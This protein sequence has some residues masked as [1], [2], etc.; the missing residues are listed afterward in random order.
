MKEEYRGW[1]RFLLYAASVHF[2][3]VYTLNTRPFLDIA[4]FESGRER[5]P[6]QYRA[7]TAW[8]LAAADRSIHIPAA[9]QTRLPPRMS[10]P[11]TFALFALVVLS[12]L[13][14]V[15]AT[16]HALNYLTGR[17]A[18]SRWGALLVIAMSYFHYILDFGHPCCTP[19]QLPYD[20]PSMAFFAVAIALI[21]TGRTALLY[22]CFAVSC[23]NRESSLFL[24]LIFALYHSATVVASSGKPRGLRWIGLH[25]AS[26]FIVWFAIRALLHHLYPLAAVP[27]AQVHGFEIHVVDNIGYLLRPYYW[28]SYLSMFAFSWIFLYA[29][30][31]YV[32]HPGIRRALWIGPI[33]LIAM[34]IVGVLSEIRIFG[35]LISLF[36]I[37][38]V[39][40]L[41]TRFRVIPSQ[42]AAPS[43][44]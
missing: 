17:P 15:Y 24:I 34:Y 44:T 7:L 27:G 4:A 43:E 16:R 31:R 35:E 20:L 21:V 39:L 37:A 25:S 5:S 2:A 23:L 28:A 18:L 19:F 1:N 33:V 40:L 13:A 26:L 36:T 6:F 29:N 11:N 14:A 8:I 9:I 30:W 32:P 38:L 42:S 3:L 12:M 22:L 10:Q 41:A